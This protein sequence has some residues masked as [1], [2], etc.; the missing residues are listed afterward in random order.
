MNKKCGIYSIIN[1]IN[2]IIYIGSST[3]LFHRKNQ[4]FSLLNLNKHFN[5]KLQNS[6]NKYGEHQFE[7]NIIEECVSEELIEKEQFWINFYKSYDFKSGFNLT[8]IAERNVLSE[9]T[10]QK[11][12]RHHSKFW[13]NKKLNDQHRKNMSKNNSKFWKNKK[14]SDDHKLK[15]SNSHKKE[16]IQIDKSGKIINQ[17]FGIKE[18]SE[19]TGFSEIGI[20]QVLTGYKRKTIYGYIFKYKN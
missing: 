16:I 1:K 6:W 8:K 18:A 13:K 9:E 12:S 2:N 11:I 7:F 14:L 5:K 10:K 15:L 3:N 20:Q 4:H 19:K 17:F